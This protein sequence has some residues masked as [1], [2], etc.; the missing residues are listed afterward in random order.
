MSLP[1]YISARDAAKAAVVADPN[2]PATD[3]LIDAADAAWAALTPE[4]VAEYEASRWTP[5]QLEARKGSL[6]VEDTK[7]V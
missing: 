2:A 1:N 6:P 7:E 3:V 5:E 4:E